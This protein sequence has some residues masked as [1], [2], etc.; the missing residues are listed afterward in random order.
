M[1]ARKVVVVLGLMGSDFVFVISVE[2]YTCHI[3][4]YEWEE[5]VK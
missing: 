5:G 2:I 4:F 3:I 1:R